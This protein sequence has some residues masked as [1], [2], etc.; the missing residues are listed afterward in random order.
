MPWAPLSLHRDWDILNR[1]YALLY[2][3]GVASILTAV[4]M[5]SNAE[6]AS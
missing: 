2:F 4:N 3:R 1:K 6:L 5:T